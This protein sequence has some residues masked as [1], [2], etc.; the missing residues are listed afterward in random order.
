MKV[1]YS[2]DSVKLYYDVLDEC[3]LARQALHLLADKW[4]VLVIY[5]LVDGTKRYSEI[6]KNIGCITHKMLAQTLRR[7]ERD[8]LLARKVYPVIPPKTEYTL[9]ELGRTLIQPLNIFFQWGE[10]H[11]ESVEQARIEYDI[12]EQNAS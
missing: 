8:G 9:T 3:C 10:E 5:A 12:K 2:E 7:L 1:T 11:M 4:T 6:H